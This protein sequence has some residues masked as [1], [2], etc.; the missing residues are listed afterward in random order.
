M[1][2]HAR[3]EPRAAAILGALL[4]DAASLGLHW[5]YDPERIAQIEKNRGL[6][7]LQP[8]ASDYADTRGYFAHGAKTAGDASAYGEISWL[9]LRHLAQHQAFNRVQYQAEYCTHFGP[10]GA[11]IGYVDSPTRQ[12]LHRLLTL[13]PE[14]FPEISGADDDQFSALAALPPLVATHTG[15]QQSLAG[16]VELVVRLTH[17]NDMAIAAAQYTSAV[18]WQ[19]LDGDPVTQALKDALPHAGQTLAPLVEEALS[20]ARL[21]SAALAK[22]FGSACHVPEG[23]PI[24]AHLAQ[25]VSDYRSAIEENIR[26]GGDSC[27]RSIMLGAIV[28]A[29]TAQRQELSGGIPLVWMARYRKLVAAAEACARL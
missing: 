14:E 6:V 15:S 20:A 21:D 2:A 25:H 27:G 1:D 8:D 24:I 11:Y 17:D 4:A 9:M 5:L 26:I 7:F 19:V 22:R 16:K 12:T 28:A 10:G 3:L 23:V 29:S 18:L 13:K